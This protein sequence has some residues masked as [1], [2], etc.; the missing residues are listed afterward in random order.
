MGPMR[1]TPSYH[2]Q[3]NLVNMIFLTVQY[4]GAVR[5]SCF[6]GTD[7][8]TGPARRNSGKLFESICL[9]SLLAYRLLY[10]FWVDVFLGSA[11]KI[12]D[13]G[14]Q[15]NRPFS[16]GTN[17]ISFPGSSPARLHKGTRWD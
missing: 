6:A 14:Q 13:Y 7:Q 9:M 16:C 3:K 11:D 15:L 8:R 2:D 12:K 4:D 10:F 17:A 1:Q 5:N